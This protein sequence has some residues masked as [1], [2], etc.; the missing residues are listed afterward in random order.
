MVE[1]RFEWDFE[2]ARSNL[3]K[4]GVSFETAIRVFTDPFA[5][6]EQDRVEDGEY[7]WQTTGVVE[8]FLVLLV[9][10]ADREED[11]I[12]VIRIISARRATTTE[13]RRYA[14]NRSI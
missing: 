13:K 7:R 5:L 12:D 4:H 1:L 2:K 10:H 8:G 11:G 14:Q 3:R 6:T 9:A